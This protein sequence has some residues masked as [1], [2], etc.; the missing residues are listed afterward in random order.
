M[1]YTQKEQ[2]KLIKR[3]QR[4]L[5]Y[6]RTQIGGGNPIS[7]V[8]YNGNSILNLSTLGF[9]NGETLSWDS[10]YH[11][12]NV[13]TGD[14]ALI[15]VGTDTMFDIHNA[16]G[17]T[18]LK[19]EV[20]YPTGTS[21]NGISNVDR[22]IANSHET[23]QSLLGFVAAD[24]L[25]GQDGHVLVIGVLDPIDT[26]G[27]SEG[28]VYLST[29]IPGA[30]TS[31]RPE[32]PDYDILLGVVDNSDVNGVLTVDSSY[33]INN[34]LFG[35]WD[36][37][38]RENI[39]FLVTSDGATIT[40]TLERTGGGDLTMKLAEGFVTLD[41]TP[42]Q[43][44]TLTP[45]TDTNPQKN[46]IYVDGAT[47]VLTVS[48][49]GFPENE[50]VKV[51]DVYVQSASK[52]QSQGPL[53][54]RNWNDH[55]KKVGDNGH[56]L[57][58]TE[59]LRQN[60]AEWFSGAQG[61]C[62]ID[63]PT[64]SNVYL[65]VTAG[66]V[67]QLHKQDFPAMDMQAGGDVHI[68]N[69]PTTPYID[70]TNL[71]GQTLDSLGASLANSSFTLVHWGVANKSGE[72]CPNMIN[73]PSG[74]YS[75]LSPQDAVDDAN[76]YTDYNI[77]DA[78]KGKGFL[79]AAYTFQL[80]SNGTDWTLFETQDLR[81]KFPNTT[82]GSGGA[83]GSGASEFTA[84][85]DTPSSYI[86]QALKGV[87]VA[88]GETGL[89]FTNF[90][91]P[92]TIGNGLTRV[93]DTITL[94]DLAMTSNVDLDSYNNSYFDIYRE[95]VSGNYGYYRHNAIRNLM[96]IRKADGLTSTLLLD[97]SGL[98]G[99]FDWKGNS[100]NGHYGWVNWIVSDAKTDLDF[101]A[102]DNLGNAKS[103]AIDSSSA[104]GLVIG[105]QIHNK[106]IVYASD[107]SAN[108][109]DRSL[110]DKGYVDTT[111]AGAGYGDVLKVG[112]PSNN[113]VAVWTGDGTIEGNNQAV[114]NAAGSSTTMELG[115]VITNSGV[116]YL[117]G[118]TNIQ[119]GWLRLYKGA[120]ATGANYIIQ[121]YNGEF[122]ITNGGATTGQFIKYNNTTQILEFG[123][124]SKLLFSNYGTGAVTG[125][126]AYTLAV[127]ASGN[128][129]EE[130][131]IDISL[132]VP[133][134]GATQTLDMNG[135][136]I[137][138]V[139]QF[140]NLDIIDSGTNT[141]ISIGKN[142]LA[143]PGEMIQIGP[144]INY[145]GS[146]GT[147]TTNTFIGST[148][149]QGGAASTGSNNIFM[150]AYA[151]ASMKHVDESV[152]IGYN[153][154]DT[155]FGYEHVVIGDSAGY[156]LLGGRN[157]AIGWQAGDYTYAQ[158]NIAI[159]TEAGRHVLIYGE[160]DDVI[161]I[162][163]EANHSIAD[164]GQDVAGAKT[165]P[166]A[167]VNI[168]TNR[169]T[170]TAHG[171]G[172]PGTVRWLN[173][174]TDG[175]L[176]AGLSANQRYLIIDANTIEAISNDVGDIDDITTQGTGNHT[177][178]AS[179]VIENCIAIG[180]D[181]NNTKS[182]QVMLGGPAITET[183]LQGEVNIQDNSIIATLQT[184]TGI[185]GTT[186]INWQNGNKAKFTFGAG[187]ETLTFTD[188][189]GVAGFTLIVQQDGVGSRT[190]T[191]PASVKWES[192]TAPTLSTGANAVDIVSFLFDGTNYYGSY[193]LNF[194]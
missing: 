76:G 36:G 27:L 97:T 52:V 115:T 92:L 85:T 148:V 43:T 164:P 101:R 9:Q 185:V 128:V 5:N 171:F 26:S 135:Q 74:S 48:T 184:Y 96:D 109:T 108:F 120:S 158:H 77:P 55:V 123:N 144:D 95:D 192:G 40:G 116:L 137:S 59:R 154:Y 161:S 57:H 188:A 191:W 125:T 104:D 150:G 65:S 62:T 173:I 160:G 117:H 50:H 60:H 86:G 151:G 189:N 53:T 28:P 159:G 103:I 71:N 68:V 174:T 6:L 132:Y 179:I 162:G 121:N 47:K 165:V 14:G 75:R 38:F 66:K 72:H 16:T 29:T 17:T 187:N 163:R 153:A 114:I 111:I 15:R 143:S 39:D 69:H 20:I 166:A 170:I 175:T 122:A 81:G 41:C 93:G 131:V 193:G 79:I 89:E 102:Y 18:L 32:Y 73:L 147:Q 139:S 70:V 105:D 178:T 106:G 22:A 145:N 63:S 181:A 49:S 177:F 142:N 2:D 100:P 82:A 45:G 141:G 129:I 149:F 11:T 156:E 33:N 42:A 130:G 94:G 146:I 176:P 67:Y 78:F 168:T 58:I 44:I 155:G 118:D 3:L 21:T 56:L 46:F 110:V 54:N 24:I 186:D 10:K 90:E 12:I 1:D 98:L 84:L 99:T 64:A 124:S 112:T 180:A 13:P 157:I 126:P 30:L 113:Q 183:V 8:D 138:N 19:G 4:D 80:A 25:D 167:N 91:N 134:T 127:D 61:T 136:E 37:S 51:A 34:T 182:N 35:A 133:Y 88:A 169:I 140:N 83:G 23:T 172:N 152:A 194:S 119:G 87:R 190:I 107:Y 31:T 7:D